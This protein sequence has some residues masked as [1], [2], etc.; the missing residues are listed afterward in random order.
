MSR[1]SP[2]HARAPLVALIHDL[3]GSVLA[4]APASVLKRGTIAGAPWYAW[5]SVAHARLP[6]R[7]DLL[8]VVTRDGYAPYWHD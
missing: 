5:R 3:D 7:T 6:S 8:D 2:K 4:E 1:T